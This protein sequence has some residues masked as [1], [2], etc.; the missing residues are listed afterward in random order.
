MIGTTRVTDGRHYVAERARVWLT[1]DVAP[2]ITPALPVLDL[3]AGELDRRTA[4]HIITAV[5]D[6][7]DRGETHYTARPGIA[8]LRHALAD[9]LA[10]ESGIAYDPQ[11]EILISSGGQEGLF[12][13]VQMLVHPGDE[14]VLADPGYPTYGDAVRLAGGVTVSVPIDPNAGVGLTAAAIEA[15]LTP[16]A[17]LL[18]LVTPDN[19]TG[20]V[21]GGDEMAKIAAL[22]V[23]HD[24]LVLFD[25]IYKAFLFDGAAHVNIAAFPGM[26]ERTVIVGSFSKEYAM[27]GWRVGYVAGAA[28]LIQPITDLKLALSICSAAPSQWAALAA[29]T[30]PRD[31]VDEMRNDLLERRAVLLPALGAM[32]LPHGNPRG[33]YYVFADIRSTGLS[34]A[35]CARLFLERA[36]VRTL[37]GHLFGPGGEGYLRIVL[38]QRASI[39]REAMAR[40]A[41]LVHDLREQTI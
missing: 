24:F 1:D 35:D 31:A 12:V 7:L 21:I 22:A 37:P 14:V 15:Y 2:A 26:R 27:T 20:A 4:P 34:S 10:A 33:A 5:S 36:G 9:R 38:C 28:H 11:T 18:I 25:E 19:P 32:G 30:G 6:A 3:A 29:L 40:L 39:I 17:R 41:P 8:P 16:R 13:A 23:R